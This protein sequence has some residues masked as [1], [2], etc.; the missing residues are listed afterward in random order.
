MIG[1]G[2]TAV[3]EALFLTNFASKVT[4]VHRRDRFRA[5]KILQD[6]LFKNPKIAVIWDTVLEDVARRRE[7][8]QGQAAS[9][10]RNVKT[11]ALTERT[12]DG[13]FIAIGHAP[14]S[15]LFVGQLE[16]KPTATSRPRR[17]RPRP[18]CPACSPPATSPTTSTARR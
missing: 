3:E 15:E 17:T 7:P 14:A 2:N 18:R 13:V 5:E 8:A 12:V 9:M 11:G 4:V 16:M 1:G 10:L 6:R